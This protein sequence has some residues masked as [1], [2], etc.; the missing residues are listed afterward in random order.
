MKKYFTDSQVNDLIGKIKCITNSQ[1][2][3]MA[4]GE[5]L[6]TSNEDIKSLLNLAVET[7]IN[8]VGYTSEYGLTNIVEN[9]DDGICVKP[10]QD[11]FYNI[12]LYSVKELG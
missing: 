8:Q 9:P 10:R 3:G 12:S 1:D 2:S 7:V 11:S 4:I 5:T 6:F